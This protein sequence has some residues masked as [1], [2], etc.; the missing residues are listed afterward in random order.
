MKK[1]LQPTGFTKQTPTGH[2]DDQIMVNDN[3]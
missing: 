3:Q 1:K 2:G